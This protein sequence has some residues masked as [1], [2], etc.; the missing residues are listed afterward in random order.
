M[1]MRSRRSQRQAKENLEKVEGTTRR[2]FRR[3]LLQPIVAI[4][5]KIAWLWEFAATWMRLLRWK[6]AAIVGENEL[7]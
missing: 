2:H 3:H 4:R 1:L 6:R 5:W 7:I